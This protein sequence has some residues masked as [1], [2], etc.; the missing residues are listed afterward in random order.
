MLAKAFPS[1]LPGKTLL[2]PLKAQIRG[3]LLALSPLIC[4]LPGLLGLQ[5][6]E[7][8]LSNLCVPIIVFFFY[9]SIR[10]LITLYWG[11]TC[12]ILTSYISTRPISVLFFEFP[13]ISTVPN[14][15]GL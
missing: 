11:M 13:T 10:A 4:F 14:T 8:N 9:K 12:K 5:K 2:I 3:Q 1:S 6:A 7:L 15:L